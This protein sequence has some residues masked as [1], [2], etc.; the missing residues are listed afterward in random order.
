MA[1]NTVGKEGAAE[2]KGRTGPVSEN[3]RLEPHVA[4]Y[5]D[6]MEKAFG[7]KADI[8]EVTEDDQTAWVV[9]Q[10]PSYGQFSM[11]IEPASSGKATLNDHDDDG[12]RDFKVA[13]PEEA[14][15]V[16]LKWAEKVKVATDLT[17]ATTQALG[18]GWTVYARQQE[19][20][21]C[22]HFKVTLAPFPLPQWTLVHRCYKY[23]FNALEDLVKQVQESRLL[24]E[25][26]NRVLSDSANKR[27]KESCNAAETL[28]D[29]ILGKGLAFEVDRTE[30]KEATHVHGDMTIKV[31]HRVLIEQFPD[32]KELEYA[33]VQLPGVETPVK[34]YAVDHS[35]V[36]KER[37]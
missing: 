29:I 18:K 25:S 16:F 32:K 36:E 20:A 27:L 2:K 1:E 3:T 12:V 5:L 24:C 22:G 37:Q 9:M 14:E 19:W 34:V 23:K 10:P 15:P 6:S 28:F 13:T 31:K 21:R 8:V 30:V 35:V 7:I 26:V 17:N 11:T 4:R 33:L